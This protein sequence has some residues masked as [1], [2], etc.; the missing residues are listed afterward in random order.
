MKATPLTHTLLALVALCLAAGGISLGAEKGKPVEPFNGRDFTGWK[1]KGD[2]SKSK[3]VVGKAEIDPANP[4]KL[5]S[6][7]GAQEMIDLATSLDIY[8]EEKFG[9][10]IIEVELMVPQHSNSGVYVMGEYEIQVLDS[11]GKAKVGP[12]DMGGLYGFSAPKVNASKKPG[13]WQTMVIEYR[14]PRFDADGKKTASTKIVKVVLNG[15]LIQ[16]N[17]ELTH[18]GGGGV[19]GREAPKGPLMFQGNH[20][21]VAYR[22]IKVTPLEGN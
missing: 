12:G 22:N 5:V 14:A 2:A 4:R 18:V 19:T 11:Y 10:A 6:Q 1:F 16:E 8:T 17:V 15:Q 3:W 20:G 9:D 13:E 21:P 7:P